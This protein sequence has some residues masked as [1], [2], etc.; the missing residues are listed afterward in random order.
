MNKPLIVLVGGG[1][2][3]ATALLIVVI[4]SLSRPIPRAGWR[5]NPQLAGGHWTIWVQTPPCEDAARNMHVD[6]PQRSGE[7]LIVMCDALPVPVKKQ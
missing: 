7:P 4:A 1:F 3:G 6:L 2:L 5:T